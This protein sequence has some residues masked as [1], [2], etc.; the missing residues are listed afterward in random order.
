M[1]QQQMLYMLLHVYIKPFMYPRTLATSMRQS[2]NECTNGKTISK[3]DMYCAHSRTLLHMVHEKRHSHTHGRREEARK[4]EMINAIH[5]KCNKCKREPF[6]SLFSSLVIKLQ[7]P[8]H[9]RVFIGGS[10]PAL[11][12]TKVTSKDVWHGRIVASAERCILYFLQLYYR[13]YYFLPTQAHTASVRVYHFIC[14]KSK[15][16]YRDWE[17]EYSVNHR[18]YSVHFYAISLCM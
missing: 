8:L 4:E 13:Y 5:K 10:E 11:R 7:H 1:Q 2:Q 14:M 9:L 3:F 16:F 17:Y 6:R 18:I 12:F 15:R